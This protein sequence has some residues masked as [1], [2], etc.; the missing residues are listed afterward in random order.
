MS[1][2]SSAKARQSVAGFG[3]IELPWIYRQALENALAAVLP[4]TQ[5]Q[6]S[7]AKSF[8]EW[9]FIEQAADRLHPLAALPTSEADLQP[10][11]HLTSA[12]LSAVK[13]RGYVV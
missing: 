4:A 2:L 11:A 12:A 8:L 5:G 10:L 3:Q 7:G 1:E 9:G 6:G 13:A